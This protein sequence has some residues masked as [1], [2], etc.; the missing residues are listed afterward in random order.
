M[1]ILLHNKF[2]IITIMRFQ[3]QIL[4][5]RSGLTPPTLRSGGSMCV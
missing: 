5:M 1:L 2:N 3:L 4:T